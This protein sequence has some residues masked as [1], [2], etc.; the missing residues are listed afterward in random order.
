MR[1]VFLLFFIA[2]HSILATSQKRWGVKAG[3]TVN[4]QTGFKNSDKK[5]LTS[6]QVS[7][8]GMLPLGNSFFLE[9]SIGYCSKGS[10]IA[11]LTFED[12]LGN[13]IGTGT[14]SLRFDYIELSVPIQYL[15][16]NNRAKLF[17]GAGPY[18]SYAMNGKEIWKNVS[19]TPSNEPAKRNIQF[20]NNGYE[21]FDVGL[22]GSLSAQ[23]Q[24]KWIA[25]INCE[26][27]VTN[28]YYSEQNK[29]R[30][31]SAGITIGYFFH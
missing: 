20:G 7:F 23:I 29:T 17:L 24:D 27:G 21:H 16:A 31:V 1:K 9:P 14:M 18:F 12:Q 22:G 11:S 4:N 25:S 8:F 26:F 30:N 19:G 2:S 28:I 15:I 13:P 3:A 5:A 10:R 6:A